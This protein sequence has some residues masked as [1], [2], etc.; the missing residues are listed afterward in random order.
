MTLSPFPDLAPTAERPIMF[1]GPMVKAILA[2]RKTMTR[3]ILKPQPERCGLPVTLQFV[4]GEDW[5]RIAVGRVI[6]KQQVRYRPGLR[7]WVREAWRSAAEFDELRPDDIGKLCRAAGYDPPWTPIIYEADGERRN[8]EFGE[9]GKRKRSYMHMPRWASRIT[10]EVAA[11]KIETVQDIVEQDAR[12]EGV[13]YFEGAF[14]RGGYGIY[15]RERLKD[16]SP[17]MLTAHVR[18][19]FASLWRSLHGPGSW[20]ANPEVVAI[21]FKRTGD[22]RNIDDHA[23]L[24]TTN[25]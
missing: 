2:G 8:W 21:S 4:D 7:L 3:R 12:R 25:A 6:T 17:S 15:D 24:E 19:S 18:E 9:P 1:S 10:L 20:E 16:G 13:E 5:P 11:V 23:L 22:G 14:M